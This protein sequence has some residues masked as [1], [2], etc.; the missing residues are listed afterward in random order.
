MFLQKH[1][2]SIVIIVFGNMICNTSCFFTS[3][4]HDDSDSC[5]QGHIIIIICISKCAEIFHRKSMHLHQFL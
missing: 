5:M 2:N 4:C 1:S 3:I